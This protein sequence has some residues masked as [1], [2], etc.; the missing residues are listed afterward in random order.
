M[1]VP[2]VPLSE[3][4]EICCLENQES[5]MRLSTRS[6]FAVNTMID[7]ALRQNSGPV[8]MLSISERLRISR[9]YAE[10]VIGKL[11]RLG[12]LQSTRGRTGGYVLG[13]DAASITVA[14]I[15]SAVEGAP[16]A[17]S[18]KPQDVPDA[19]CAL[20]RDLWQ[21]LNTKMTDYLQ[22]ITLDQLLAQQ[23]AKGAHNEAGASPKPGVFAQRAPTPAKL[24]I[25]NSV[26]ELHKLLPGCS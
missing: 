7:V 10:Q 20:T 8:A 2:T 4:A 26:F 23:I 1:F 5:E 6:R 22:S 24:G 9:T 25:P 18:S 13:R 19:G 14:D 12:L 11:R 15:I 21:S 17:A 3:T 16:A